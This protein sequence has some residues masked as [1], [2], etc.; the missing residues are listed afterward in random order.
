MS[1]TEQELRIV[2]GQEQ[3]E[4]R[5]KIDNREGLLGLVA[6]ISL[7]I[8]ALLIEQNLEPLL[9]PLKT[10]RPWIIP[11][12]LLS[13]PGSNWLRSYHIILLYLLNQLIH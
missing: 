4:V 10:R 11:H 7:A 12:R 3:G 2:S 9:Q 13:N 1:A 5:A 8:P 6:L